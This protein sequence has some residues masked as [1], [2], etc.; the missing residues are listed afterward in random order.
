LIL[1]S[2]T[3]QI[4]QKVE[5]LEKGIGSSEDEDIY[6]FIAKEVNKLLK[7]LNKDDRYDSQIINEYFAILDDK[8]GI[9]YQKRK[10]FD[11][12]VTRIN[13]EISKFLNREQIKLQKVY[14]HYFDIY[15]TDGVDYNIYIGQSISPQ[16][17]FHNFYLKNLRLWQ[18]S[19]MCKIVAIVHNLKKELRIPLET[20]QL[21]LVQ[22]LPITIKFRYEE[23][24]F[25]IDSAY[26]ARYEIVKKRIDKATIAG[27]GERLTQPGMIAIVYSNNVILKE[28]AKYI[29]FLQHQKIITHEVEYLDLEELQGTDE[30]KALR[31][32]VNLKSKSLNDE[33]FT[34]KILEKIQV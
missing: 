17:P 20:A 33:L 34:E 18:L 9:L 2:L 21:I 26:N 8:V 27:S 31:I 6:G 1:N 11:Q 32:Q 24:R 28:Y 4:Q 5:R 23:K 7:R 25:D 15:Q 30:L 16:R 3:L 12:S 29:E 13:V 10:D 19:S 22:N 14:P